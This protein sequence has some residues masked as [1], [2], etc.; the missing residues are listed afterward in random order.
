MTKDEFIEVI[1]G[2]A[3]KYAPQFGIKVISPII[4][5]ACLES[6]YGTSYKAQFHNYFGL[7]YRDNRVTCNSGTF[8]DGG[9]EQ[10]PDGSYTPVTD[11]WYAFK[12]LDQGVLGYFQ[13]TAAKWYGEIKNATT[14][15]EYLLALKTAGYA[16][17][18]DYV[19][20][21]LAVIE[22]WDLTEY[23]R[24]LMEV[25]PMRINVHAGHGA[26]GKGAIGAVGILDESVEDRKVKDEVIRILREQGHTVYDCT[27]DSGTQSEILNAIVKKCNSHEVD[28]DVSIHFNS[29]SKDSANGTEVL[30]YSA[31]STFAKEKATA[32]CAAIANLGYKNRGVKCQPNL[33]YLKGT[34]A[35]ALLVECCFVTSPADIA[36]YNPKTMAEAIAYGITGVKPQTQNMTANTVSEVTKLYRVQ[37]GAYAK[38]ENAETMASSLKSAGF[39][40]IIVEA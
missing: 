18:I 2:T 12:N 20:K 3:A 27:V 39:T 9:A 15:Y 23:D 31:G 5:Q 30:I 28:L 29:F 36:K 11:K 40:G 24:L 1:A 7:K 8:V 16:T 25:K 14:A 17:S 21:V 35:Q 34:K 37:V 13:F 26:K 38:R 32:I 33:A 6:A 19:D 10:N 22:K 4:A